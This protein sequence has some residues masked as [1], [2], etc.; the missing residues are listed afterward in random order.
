MA[1]TRSKKKSPPKSTLKSPPKSTLKSTNKSAHK[2][3]TPSSTSSSHKAP[4]TRTATT[5]AKS[6]R[7]SG[8]L[9]DAPEVP[10]GFKKGRMFIPELE[11]VRAELDG[12][13]GRA[14]IVSLARKCETLRTKTEKLVDLMNARDTVEMEVTAAESVVANLNR[15]LG[16]LDRRVASARDAVEGWM[17]DAT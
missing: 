14:G 3:T 2:T 11:I 13:D 4:N 1:A 8:D 6:R 5:A 10:K 12:K 7:G 16:A 17:A 9:P 15:K